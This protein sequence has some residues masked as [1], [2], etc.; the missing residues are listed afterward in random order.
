MESLKLPFG[1]ILFMLLLITCLVFPYEKVNAQDYKEKIMQ[2]S[3]K[4][5]Y[6]WRKDKKLKKD[7]PHVLMLQLENLSSRKVTVSFSVLFFWKAQLHSSS[8]LKEYCLKP[9]KKIKGKKWGLAFNSTVFTLN[10]YLDPMFSWYIE[11]LKVKEND[12]CNP[13][14]KLKLESAYP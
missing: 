5:S 12:S 9:G 7:S 1:R 2:D 4:I 3:I 13:R 11:D 10:E 14:L 8:N 6:K